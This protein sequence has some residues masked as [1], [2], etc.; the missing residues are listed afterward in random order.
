[1]GASDLK[2]LTKTYL[3]FV[4]F[5]GNIIIGTYRGICQ[6]FV[7]VIKHFRV[8]ITVDLGA[9]IGGIKRRNEL[10]ETSFHREVITI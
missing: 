10:A 9:R 1:M 2:N 8:T 6:I 3:G 5:T 4:A 7:Q